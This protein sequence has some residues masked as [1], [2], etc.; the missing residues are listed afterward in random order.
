LRDLQLVL[1]LFE[2]ALAFFVALQS[3]TL[4]PYIR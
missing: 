2:T 1:G 4:C 3:L